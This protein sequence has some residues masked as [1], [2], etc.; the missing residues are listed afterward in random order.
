[1]IKLRKDKVA[2][3]QI[4][5]HILKRISSGDLLKDEPIGTIRSL[6]KDYVVTTKTIQKAVDYLESKKAIDRKQSLGIFVSVSMAEANEILREHA[7][8]LTREYIKDLES[9]GYQD[10]ATNLIKGVKNND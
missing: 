3:I 5:I 7:L 2:Y 10:Q 9:I 6:S 4:G 1:M 8:A